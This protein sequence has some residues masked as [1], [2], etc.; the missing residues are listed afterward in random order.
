MAKRA[1]ENF[2]FRSRYDTAC[3]GRRQRWGCPAAAL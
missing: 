3:C 2:W 1:S